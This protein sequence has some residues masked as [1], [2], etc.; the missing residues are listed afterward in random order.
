MSAVVNVE[1]FT[2]INPL[3]L[4]SKGVIWN[5]N[6]H[7][8]LSFAR[9]SPQ[10]DVW[11]SYIIYS[12]WFKQQPISDQ[13]IKSTT[14]N[15]RTTIDV[16]FSLHSIG[17]TFKLQCFFIKLNIEMYQ[18]INILVLDFVGWKYGCDVELDQHKHRKLTVWTIQFRFEKLKLLNTPVGDAEPWCQ[19]NKAESPFTTL[20]SIKYVN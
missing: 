7:S 15:P 12:L 4:R 9:D 13:N 8:P 2:L 11:S 6:I 10:F 5:R 18:L 19:N 1:G 16:F 14:E 17:I 3:T 20:I